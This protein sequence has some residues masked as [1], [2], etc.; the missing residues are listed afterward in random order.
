[1]HKLSICIPTFN[2]CSHLSNCLN[3]IILNTN[4]NKKDVQIC[5]SDNCSTDE[6]EA[7]VRHAQEKIDIVYRKNK[8]NLGMSINFLNVIN[9][10]DGKYAWIIGDDDLLMPNTFERLLKI[11]DQNNG[12]NFFYINSFH[13]ATEYVF[14]QHQPFDTKNLPIK[15]E[16]FSKWRGSGQ[17][18]FFELINPKISF[19]FLGGMFLSVFNREKWIENSHVLDNE[20][21]HDEKIFSH[22]D[23]TFPHV[24]IF[25]NAFSNSKAY[26]HAEPLSVCLTGAREWAP[27]YPFIRSVRLIEALDEYRKNGLPYVTY[28]RCKN[29]ALR[30]FIPD[31]VYTYIHKKE[32]GYEHVQ[33]FK[34]F[35]S[36]GLYP[37]FY[38]SF[39]RYIIRKLRA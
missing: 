23:N 14:E 30:T 15:M 35:F 34:L 11:M 33:F 18:D 16:E 8:T 4:Y 6:T 17:M 39:F 26:F 7:V 31:M 3:S 36:N 27:M 1:M 22:F 20:A 10:A 37:E 9:M 25:A 19:D 32:S 13:L 12:V 24:K 29:F 5:V 21:I 2:R 28:W 38:W